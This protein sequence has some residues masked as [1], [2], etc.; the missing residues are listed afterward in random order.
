LETLLITLS[1]IAQYK[2]ISANLNTDK[3]VNPFI[4]EAQNIDLKKM[5]GNSFFYDLI[6]DFNDSPSLQKYNTLFNGGTW[7]CGNR[8][9]THKGLKTVLVYLSSSRIT[10][11]SNI[12]ATAFGQVVKRNEYSDKV[13]ESTLIRMIEQDK[14]TALAFFDDVKKYMD[15]NKSLFPLWGCVSFNRTKITGA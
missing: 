2:A 10:M 4:L 5:L 9:Y 11:A 8:S 15:D 7:T 12:E 13:S 6:A 3:K 14:S 1:D